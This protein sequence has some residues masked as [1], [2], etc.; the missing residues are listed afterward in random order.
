MW[1]LYRLLPPEGP[2]H[3]RVYRG[4]GELIDHVFG[5][6]RLVNPNTIPAGE[7]VAGAPLPSMSDD[8]TAPQ[9]APSDHAAV[10]AIFSV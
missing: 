1:N 4:R 9:A 2:S 7:I 5:S 8:P 10:V 3:T 6:H